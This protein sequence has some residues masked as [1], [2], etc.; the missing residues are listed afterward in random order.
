MVV[1]YQLGAKKNNF[2][3]FERICAEKNIHSSFLLSIPFK[4]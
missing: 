1:P 4:M 2:E 3:Y